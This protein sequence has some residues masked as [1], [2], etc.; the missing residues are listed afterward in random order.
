MDGGDVVVASE[1]FIEGLDVIAFGE[2]SGFALDEVADVFGADFDVELEAD[3]V[4][5]A[6]KGLVGAGVG[7]GEEGGA[8]WEI[9]GVAVPVE[10]GERGRE[11]AEEGMMAGGVEGVNGEPADFEFGVL[12]DF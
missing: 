2:G 12:V 10:G 9:E 5:A 6:D 3:D 7:A 11:M 8:G 1:D 4:V